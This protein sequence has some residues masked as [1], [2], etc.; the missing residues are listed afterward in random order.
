MELA[1][2][3]DGREQHAPGS[4]CRR[5]RLAIDKGRA[6]TCP[7]HHDHAW[8]PKHLEANGVGEGIETDLQVT[9]WTWVKLS[10]PSPS[11]KT[12]EFASLGGLHD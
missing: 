2:P 1:R 10:E 9:P 6:N 5:A 7:H 4:V 12:N 8:S 3:V 11:K